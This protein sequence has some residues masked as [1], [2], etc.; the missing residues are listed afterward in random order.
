MERKSVLK[1]YSMTMDKKAL[2]TVVAA[3]IRL[4]ISILLANIITIYASTDA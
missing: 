4:V 2:S 1:T 3:L